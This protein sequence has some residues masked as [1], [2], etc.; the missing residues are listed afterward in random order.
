MWLDRKTYIDITERQ[1][2]ADDEKQK[3]FLTNKTITIGR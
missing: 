1:D 2:S 3:L